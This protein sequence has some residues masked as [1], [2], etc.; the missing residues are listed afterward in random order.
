M[1]EPLSGLLLLEAIICG[2]PATFLAA[3]YLPWAAI[4]ALGEFRSDPSFASA[5]G[6]I[7]LASLFSLSHYWWL[8]IAT[9]TGRRYQFGL[10]YY[11]AACCAL[12]V[13]VALVVMLPPISIVA[14]LAAAAVIHFTTIQR[15]RSLLASTHGVVGESQ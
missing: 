2:I 6:A 7:L 14:L 12:G 1:K 15:N 11:T 13:A 5:I 9:C 8:A 10:G 4:S 3:I